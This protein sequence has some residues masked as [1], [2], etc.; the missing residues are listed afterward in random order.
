MLCRWKSWNQNKEGRRRCRGILNKIA[1]PFINILNKIAIPFHPRA[2]P[3]MFQRTRRSA[4]K[5]Q[6][7]SDSE[8][9]VQSLNCDLNGSGKG[10]EREREKEI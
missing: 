9:N 3:P 6:I 4:S 1:I 5:F 10:K 7:F 2:F 8:E